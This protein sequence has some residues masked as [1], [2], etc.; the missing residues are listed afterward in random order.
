MDG[1]GLTASRHLRRAA[2]PPAAPRRQRDLAEPLHHRDLD[3]GTAL[4]LLQIHLRDHRPRQIGDVS[5]RNPIQGEYQ[6]VGPAGV[7]T[8]E[9]GEMRTH[10]LVGRGDV[11]F[12]QVVDHRTASAGVTTA[13]VNVEPVVP[14]RRTV[15]YSPTD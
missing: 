4:L 11:L 9:V 1:R 2:L 15:W 12:D 7:A 14:V 6:G 3:G 10:G 13:P 5:G 8:A